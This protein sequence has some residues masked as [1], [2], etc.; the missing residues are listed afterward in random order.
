[1][2]EGISQFGF[3]SEKGLL[4]NTGHQIVC[5]TRM[6]LINHHISNDYGGCNKHRSNFFRE[7]KSFR[8]YCH[9]DVVA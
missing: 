7:W 9:L 8:Q 1:M 2:Y 6:C 3:N 5:S 4:R